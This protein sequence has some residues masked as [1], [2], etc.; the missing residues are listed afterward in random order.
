MF[1]RRS[2]NIAELTHK[3]MVVLQNFVAAQQRSSKQTAITDYVSAA[4]VI[5]SNAT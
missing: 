4:P 5:C 3:K 1:H 2:G